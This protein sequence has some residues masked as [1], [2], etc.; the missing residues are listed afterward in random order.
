VRANDAT[1]NIYNALGSNLTVTLPSPGYYD[2]FLGGGAPSIFLNWDQ[3]K[4]F[5]IGSSS[6]TGATVDTVSGTDGNYNIAVV[7]A[8]TTTIEINGYG[9]STITAGAGH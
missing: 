5:Q 9:S 3:T 6:D 1:N 7:G 2:Q 4:T 8:A